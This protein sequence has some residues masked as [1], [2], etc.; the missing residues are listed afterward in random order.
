MASKYEFIETMR[1]DTAEYAY[2]V[3]FMCEHLGVSRSGY[4]QGPGECLDRPV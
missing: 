1:L 3:G 2:P 4:Y